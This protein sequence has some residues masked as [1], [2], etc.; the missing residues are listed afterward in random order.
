MKRR[1]LALLSVIAVTG[2]GSVAVAL[3]KTDYRPQEECSLCSGKSIL[4]LYKDVNGIG[5]LNFNNF[6]VYTLRIC[7]EESNMSGSSSTVN[8]SGE[9]RSVVSI[10]SNIDR[11]IA[12]VEISLR[13][14][15]RPDRKEMAEFLCVD[16][17][18]R[19]E[20]EN[21]YDIG[22]IDYQTW[23]IHPIQENSIEFYMGDYAIHKI[24]ADEESLEYLV[25]YAPLRQD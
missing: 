16:C 11:R 18:K 6:T 10:D 17:C 1:A 15:S 13:K 25:F 5:V 12:D 2:V 23:E 7:D 4:S 8:S 19:I 22:F 3:N 9:F 14:D 24:K 21:Q 20:D